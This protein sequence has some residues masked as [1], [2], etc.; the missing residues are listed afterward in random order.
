M[1]RKPLAWYLNVPRR[2][3]L[4]AFPALAKPDD[5]WAVKQLTPALAELYLRMPPHERS[6]GVGTARRLIHATGSADPLLVKGALLHD[7]GKLGSP[8]SVL[9]RILAHLLPLADTPPEPRY[10][11][12]KGARQARRHHPAY[13]A[14]L[15][16]AAGGPDELAEIVEGHH[17]AEVSNDLAP[18]KAADE[19]S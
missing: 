3:L 17:D 9:L 5:A 15:I 10:L 11:G 6:H 7:V 16:V 18:L 4:T 1:G 14:A 13:G 2:T 12:L 8:Q 19:R